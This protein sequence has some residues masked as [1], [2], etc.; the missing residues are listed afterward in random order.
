MAKEDKKLEEEFE[1]SGT[2]CN[3]VCSVVFK[4]RAD[5]AF[6]CPKAKVKDRQTNGKG[7]FRL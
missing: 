2:A 6:R 4:P 7:W 3:I 5:L 1:Y